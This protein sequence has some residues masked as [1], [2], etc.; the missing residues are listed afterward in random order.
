MSIFNR[1]TQSQHMINYNLLV[2]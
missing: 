1:T 2:G